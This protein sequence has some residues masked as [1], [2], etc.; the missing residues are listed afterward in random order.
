VVAFENPPLAL[1]RRIF[2]AANLPTPALTAT[3]CNQSA[4]TFSNNFNGGFVYVPR[5]YVGPLSAAWVHWAR[6]LFER[7]FWSTC[8]GECGEGKYEEQVA[9]A[10]SLS[11]TGIPFFRSRAIST[12]QSW[13]RRVIKGF[14]STTACR[15]RCCTTM[16]L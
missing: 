3:G 1:L 6:W 4:I 9:M 7:S 14:F 12:T 16:D 8:G 13:E 15:S 11:E 10:L 2:E 5:R